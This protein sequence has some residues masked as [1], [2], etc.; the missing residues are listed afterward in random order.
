MS[1]CQIL[2]SKRIDQE[3]RFQLLSIRFALFFLAFDKMV[4]RPDVPNKGRIISSEDQAPWGILAM[5]EYF[6]TQLNVTLAYFG[7]RQQSRDEG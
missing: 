1:V 4:L 6:K 2:S 3:D 7:D 5:Q